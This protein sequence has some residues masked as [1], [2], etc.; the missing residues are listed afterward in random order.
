[1]WENL[2]GRFMT[3]DELEEMDIGDETIKRPTYVKAGL[4]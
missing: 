2:G 4:T 1:M 3:S